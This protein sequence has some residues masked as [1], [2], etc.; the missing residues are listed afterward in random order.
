MSDCRGTAGFAPC[1][2][3]SMAGADKRIDID[4]SSIGHSLRDVEVSWTSL[5]F[6]WKASLIVSAAEWGK[7]S[8]SVAT[9]KKIGD[10]NRMRWAERKKGEG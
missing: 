7:R 5:S 6:P 4:R 10:A 9:R 2:T 3:R 1:L 8:Q